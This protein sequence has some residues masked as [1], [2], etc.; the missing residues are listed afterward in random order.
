M[1]IEIEDVASGKT[2]V[3][4]YG[5]GGRGFELSIGVAEDVVGLMFDRGFLASRAS[6]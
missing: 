5:A 6:L 4:A 1:R 2:V 3:H